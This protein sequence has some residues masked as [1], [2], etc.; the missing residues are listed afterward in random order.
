MAV[1]VL[2]IILFT[3]KAALSEIQSLVEL[4]IKVEL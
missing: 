4:Y 1:L 3:I 2:A